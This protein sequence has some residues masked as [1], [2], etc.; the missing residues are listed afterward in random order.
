MAFPELI[1]AAGEVVTAFKALHA[2]GLFYCDISDG[3]LFVDPRSG[4]ILICDNDNVGST[5]TVRL[6]LGTPRYMAPEI[7]RGEASPGAVTDLF[8]MAVLLFLLLLN[9]HPLQGAAEFRIRCF[10]AAAMGQLYGSDPVFIFDPDDDSN[11]PVPAVHVNAPVFWDIYPE[12]LRRVFTKA[13]TEGL[14]DPGRRP[15]FR[16]WQTALAAV[17]DAMVT[18][19]CGKKN[20]YDPAAARLVCWRCQQEIVPPQRLVLDGRRVVVLAKHTKLYERHLT[21]LGDNGTKGDV[22]AAVVKHPTKDLWGLQNLG[23]TPWF[24]QAAGSPARS[25]DPGKSAAL[26]RGTIIQF[27]EVTAVVE[28]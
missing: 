17:E 24:A 11:R 26:R 8:S 13:F 23:P 3:N 9:D 20:F 12:V 10:D 21:K 14:H 18:C 4:D 5:R 25:V 2:K 27:G 6:V 1:R 19:A 7:V 15:A 22:R 16:E 28:S